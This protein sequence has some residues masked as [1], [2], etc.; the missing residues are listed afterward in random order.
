[1]ESTN[2]NKKQITDLLKKYLIGKLDNLSELKHFDTEKNKKW[3]NNNLSKNQKKIW[4]KSN[5]KEINLDLNNSE[6][7]DNTFDK[8]KNFFDIAVNKIILLNEEYSLELKE[9]FKKPWEIVEY[10]NSHI[11]KKENEILKLERKNDTQLYEDL[12]LQINAIQDSFKTKKA[13]KVKSLIIEKELNPLKSL[14]MWNWVDNSCLD[15][16]ST[17]WNYWSSITN[18]IDVN[19]WVFWIKTWDWKIIWRVLVSIDDGWNIIRSKMYYSWNTDINL[20]K[21]F[22][23][24]LNEIVD[25]WKFWKKWNEKKVSLIEWEKWYKDWIIEY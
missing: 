19:K 24:F 16:Y 2:T 25:R 12:K 17:V 15:Y 13:I 10:F 14:M 8:V 18:S 23:D 11:K 7:V 1:M 6:K 4:L 20:N 5:K 9:K 3:L 22:N 21:Y